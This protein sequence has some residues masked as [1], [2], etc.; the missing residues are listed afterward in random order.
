MEILLLIL[1]IL[2]V[3]MLL[4][5]ANQN[6]RDIEEIKHEVHQIRHH[7]PPQPAMS[8]PAAPPATPTPE[9]APAMTAPATPA[10][11][12]PVRPPS[13]HPEQPQRDA[14]N[15]LQR[16]I[17]QQAQREI[18][19]HAQH[20]PEPELKPSWFERWLKENP[21]IE[22]FIGE[23]LVNKI[24]I[25][26]LVLGIAFFVKYAIDQDW[27]N[28]VGRVCIGLLCGAI[29]VT[30]AHR[31]RKGY[32]S[33]SSV[34]VGGGLSVFYFTIAFAFHQYHLLGQTTAFT[35]MVIITAFAVGLSLLYNRIELGIL[36]TIG[37]FITPFLVSNGTANYPALFTYL[38]VLN[39]GLI[40][41]AYY[42]RWRILNFL[43]FF[44]TQLIYLTWVFTLDAHQGGLYKTGFF[45]GLLYYAMFFIMNIVHHA[46]RKS[47]LL[48]FDFII[49]LS[50]NLAFY[51][52]GMYLLFMGQWNSLEG[53]FTACL[54]IINLAL[55]YFFYKQSK[56]DKNFVFLLIGL[57]LTFI[58]LAAPVQ[59]KG[60]AIT[61]FWG[62][63]AVVLLWL[64]QKSFIKLLK[65][66]SVLI[67]VL[68]LISLIMDWGQVYGAEAVKPVIIN[69][70]FITG[71]VCALEMGLISYMFRR[72]GDLYYY[73]TITNELV[74]KSY[75]IVCVAL[76][77]IAGCL[78]INDQF[79]NRFSI[80][81]F[82][83]IYLQLYC[84]TFL[85]GLIYL[86][87][88]IRRTIGP[89]MQ[90]LA[91]G[92]LFLFYLASSSNDLDVEKAVLLHSMYKGF[93]L[94]HWV[95][96]VLLLCC[97]GELIRYFMNH[98]PSLSRYISFITWLFSICI[99]IILSLELRIALIW[100]V[101]KNPASFDY[102]EN[103][104]D[105]AGLSI[106]WGLY[107][108]AQ[109]VLGIRRRFKTLRIIALVTFG[110]TLLKLFCLDII[111]ISPAGK[112]IAFILLG[113]LLLLI[114]F[115][116]Q[117]VKKMIVDDTKHA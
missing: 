44:F 8:A 82:Q 63:E 115:M 73:R 14:N 2:L 15:Q 29:L 53:L 65:L 38:A 23:N 56:A 77:F 37:G 52:G 62:A 79:T 7:P 96:T 67:T 13:P 107:S 97:L 100:M 111:D 25:A 48:A 102:A 12:P 89:T 88:K 41:L 11:P 87:P 33:F 108:F 30:L 110:V 95:S 9:A 105:K 113:V 90:L 75:F 99:L 47:K 76:L 57:T 45:F 1:I 34:L 85:L 69:M 109:I 36:A 54:G 28:K 31:T 4:I 116:Y 10:P 101:Y 26:V 103:L 49:L 64:Y 55:A 81:G 93:Y 112:I 27:I 70:G 91:T 46:T 5:K 83:W 80:P 20:T 6:A 74:R 114:S 18:L 39:A 86:L 50:V 60:Q 92:F 42:K 59:L 58:S 94:G 78:E 61:L 72:E 16:D 43:G 19:Q 68:M 35:I 51:A 3:I 24:G 17:L 104:F 106:L 98:Q 66:V 40:V 21:D 32:H 71:I 117:R 22:K 84:Y